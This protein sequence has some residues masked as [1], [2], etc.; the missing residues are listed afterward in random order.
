MRNF[1]LEAVIFHFQVLFPLQHVKGKFTKIQTALDTL[2][3][4]YQD[5]ENNMGV[6]RDNTLLIQ[7]VKQAASMFA[8]LQVSECQNVT[9]AAIQVFTPHGPV[10][11]GQVGIILEIL[12]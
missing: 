5:Q 4:F 1:S 9:K 10:L 12:S 7:A 8:G 2:P 11:F 3:Q 6:I